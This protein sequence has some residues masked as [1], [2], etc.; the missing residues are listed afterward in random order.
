MMYLHPP[1]YMYEG[2]PV[3]PDYHDPRQFYYFPNRPHLAVDEQNRPAIR[4]LIYKEN[5]DEITPEEEH[6]TGFLVFDT[7][8]AWP[9][10]TLDKVA[11]KIQD[12]QNLDELPRLSPLLYKKGSCRLV[13]LDRSTPAPG[14]EPEEPEDDDAPP[15]PEKWVTFL[16][17]SGMPSLYGENRAIFSAVL[18]KKAT[19]LLFGAFEGFV[20]AG[21][22]YDLDFVGMQRAFN[23]HVTADWEQ[24]YHHLQ[25]GTSVDLFFFSS[26]VESIV[27]DLIDKKII[28]IEASLEGAG[29]EAMEGEFNAV[30]KELQ[31][32]V[33]DK[34]FKPQPNPN[35]PD[36]QPVTDTIVDFAR[37][38]R[39][40]G[41]PVSVGFSRRE[42]DMTE[43]RS[44]DMDYTVARAVERKIAPQAHISLFF[45]DFN[46]TR[47]QVVTVVNGA[48][49]FWKEVEFSISA[50]ADF[51]GDGLFG[52]NV[53]VSYGADDPEDASASTWSFLLDKARP[54]VKKAAW[55]DPDV[56]HQYHYRYGVVFAPGAVPGPDAPLKS[57]WRKD[58]GNIVVVTPGELYRKRRVE[59]QISQ[60]FPQELYP[61]IHAQIRYVDPQTG[62]RHE[63]GGLLDAKEPRKVFTFRTRRDAPA[64]VEY[65]FTYLRAGG[66]IETPWR[67]SAAELVLVPDPRP[68]TK[69]HVL[70]AGDRSKIQEL[71]V[72]FRYEDFDNGVFESGMLRINSTNINDAHTW[73]FAPADPKKKRYSYSQ[74]LLDTDGN[75][76][77]TGWVQAEKNTL[78]VGVLYVKRWD[79]QPELVGPPLSDNGVES[80]KL[81]LRYRDDANNH[82]AEKQILFSQPG[83]GE[84]WQLQ[85]KDASVRSYTYQIAYVLS[86]GFERKVGPLSSS[87]TFL[88][89]SSVPPAG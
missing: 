13:F 50:N 69:V 66:V 8:L 18:T 74:T 60:P 17:T 26:E 38:L 77:T 27:D 22:I 55:F 56:G 48:D 35:K 81:S 85:L 62:W 65:R 40:L 75:I 31:Q 46:L 11:K 88:M 25:E 42:L 3:V 73:A 43:I 76:I 63:D 36:D 53:D 4:F 9:E 6:A 29:D 7:S 10:K 39:N 28:K 59:V 45:E 19:A 64:D 70:V 16:E 87:D 37:D 5:L 1:F 84:V 14:E 51:D 80:V 89:I 49:E 83:P 33:L 20:P 2:V 15:P 30:R 78:P 68:V 54:L 67:T 71:I 41:S 57:G 79:V 52:V 34:F 47:D 21:V 82:S 61:Q 24:V 23:V 12:D 32:F 72:D 58:S 44:I 86:T